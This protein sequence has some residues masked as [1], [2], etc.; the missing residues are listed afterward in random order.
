MVVD[1]INKTLDTTAI[2]KNTDTDIT[3]RTILYPY[4]DGHFYENWELAL[5]FGKS[6]SIR[7]T[8]LF[9]LRIDKSLKTVQFNNQLLAGENKTLLA[10]MK[11]LKLL[12]E[13]LLYLCSYSW[14]H[15]LYES[16]NNKPDLLLLM[17][18]LGL[19]FCFGFYS[20]ITSWHTITTSYYSTL[21]YSLLYFWFTRIRNGS[22]LTLFNLLS[23]VVYLFMMNK[24]SL[25]V[26][27]NY[28]EWYCLGKRSKKTE[29]III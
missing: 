21:H 27:P 9:T 4:F 8:N 3:Y 25:I 2:V 20:S 1:I 6:R 13:Q 29:I 5:F 7:N 17:G 10:L 14:I 22:T 23:L 15:T 24:G 19:F 28:Y 26:S 18:I 16:Q 11:F 12:V